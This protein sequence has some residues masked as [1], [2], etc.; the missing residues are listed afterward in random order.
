MD[1]CDLSTGSHKNFSKAP[2]SKTQIYPVSNGMA[3]LSLSQPF[4][5]Q[6]GE[7]QL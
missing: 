3:H 7:M 1:K 4:T 5:M 6:Q 2:S